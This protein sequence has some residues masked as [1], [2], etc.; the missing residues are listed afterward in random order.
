MKHPTDNN[1]YMSAGLC[2]NCG[3]GTW[4]NIPKGMRRVDFLKSH[5]CEDCGCYIIKEE[6]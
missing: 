2:S 4:F 5:K 6:K 1:V 3:H